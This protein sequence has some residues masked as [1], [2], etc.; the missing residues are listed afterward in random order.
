MIIASVALIVALTTL[1]LHPLVTGRG[2]EPTS[3]ELPSSVSSRL[4][5]LTLI[6]FEEIWWTGRESLR[7]VVES[8]REGV[9]LRGRGIDG[10]GGC[11]HM[12]RMKGDAGSSSGG[13][14]VKDLLGGRTS[15]SS[16]SSS[17]YSGYYS[18]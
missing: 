14:A 10:F 9:G 17:L 16:S 5:K 11:G 7:R 3:G 4:G 2:F 15:D 6:S 18:G 12:G 1:S 8:V 13:W